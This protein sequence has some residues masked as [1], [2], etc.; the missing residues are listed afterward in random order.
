M[1]EFKI[2]DDIVPY[3]D[4]VDQVNHNVYYCRQNF[5]KYIG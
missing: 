5:E 1:V 3:L 2:V 4:A